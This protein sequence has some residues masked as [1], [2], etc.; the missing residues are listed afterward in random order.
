MKNIYFL[1]LTLILILLKASV[2]SGQSN[3]TPIIVNPL[4][5]D[6]LSL[7]ERDYYILFPDIA[8][9]QTAVFYLN[10]DS[11]L[12]ADV[13][14][15]LDGQQRDTL[16]KNYKNLESLNYHIYA[17]YA[18]DHEHPESAI[19][20]QPSDYRRG[21]QI[22]IYN[23]GGELISGELLSVRENSLVILKPD[24]DEDLTN[25]D[26]ITTAKNSEVNK[27]TIKGNSNLA[28][29]L[30]IGLL[31]SL[32][33]GAII[34]A[35]NQ[36]SSSNIFS[37]IGTTRENLRYIGISTGICLAAGVLIGILTST[38]DEVV[39]PFTEDELEGLSSYSR[40]PLFEPGRLKKIK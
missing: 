33:A 5:G 35:V 17:R 32:L 10:P 8:G 34:Y 16:I 14:Y 2:T 23:E 6:T 36:P 11:S 21:S 15:T 1:I 7:K 4:I 12:S 18:L 29:G 9:F 22:N 25:L 38:P 26:C 24:C 39:E 30:G 40:Y 31:A 13:K 37:N 3:G 27:L 28:L 19:N 20:I